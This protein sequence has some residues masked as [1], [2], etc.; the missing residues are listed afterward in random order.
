[1]VSGTR[2]RFFEVVDQLVEEVQ[3]SCAKRRLG[4]GDLPKLHASVA[5][6]VTDSVAITKGRKQ[7]RWASIHLNS[8]HYSASRYHNPE[9]TY[10]IH[11]ERAYDTL[12]G[13]QYLTEVKAGVYSNANRYLTRY[14]ATDKLID[15]F[16]DV[17][18]VALHESAPRSENTELIRIQIRDDEGRKYLQKYDDNDNTVRMREQ[19][20]FIND[21]LAKG[22]FDLEITRE[23][24]ETLEDRM[25][26]RSQE[27]NEGDG[28]LR[29]QDVSLYRVFND[30]EFATGGRF[31]G[32]WWQVIPSEYRTRIRINEKRTV[33][34]DFGTL[35]PTMLYSE[36]G[37]KPPE[38]SYQ[39]GLYPRSFSG[40]NS[41]A[42][43]RKLVKRCFNAML[44][45]SHRLSR[46]PR[47]VDL[48]VWGLKWHQMVEAILDRHKPIADQFFTGRGL[49]LQREDS[50]MAANL[51]EDFARRM[52]LVPLL[53]VHDSFICHHGYESDVYD[54]MKREFRK[55]YGNSVS[56]NVKRWE[57]DPKHIAFQ[58]G[59]LSVFEDPDVLAVIKRFSS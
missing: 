31:Y 44:N 45:A 6:L 49:L 58:S 51:M 54:A 43:Y 2:T 37:L 52:G 15:L 18:R 24:L 28:R 36:V 41:M 40:A 17:E 42:A 47:D 13:L 11:V 39:I 9:I 14:E 23:E 21:V 20:A 27:R 59:Q 30:T 1:M 33:E 12:I 38:D 32:G 34:L 7:K 29:L 26:Q 3:T 46:P 16:S 22:K 25:H 19:V 57:D 8:L 5:K 10:R 53:P 4:K 48:S 35:H 56:V 50:D 55:R